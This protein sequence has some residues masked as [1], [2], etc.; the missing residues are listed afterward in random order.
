MRPL[1]QI[2]QQFNLM[3]LTELARSVLYSQDERDHLVKMRSIES[4]SL[5]LTKT[6]LSDNHDDLIEVPSYETQRDCLSQSIT[7]R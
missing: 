1:L 7:K 6:D 2:S 4:H 5:H 3:K